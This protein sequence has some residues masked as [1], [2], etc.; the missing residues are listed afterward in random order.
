MAL[1]FQK[2]ETKVKHKGKTYI[3]SAKTTR[4]TWVKRFPKENV[5]RHSMIKNNKGYWLKMVDIPESQW[6]YDVAVLISTSPF[7]MTNQLA[8]YFK[9]PEKAKEWI[10]NRRNK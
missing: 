6:T 10:E 1:T 3:I 5:G 9:S 4:D 2:R 7:Y 8:R